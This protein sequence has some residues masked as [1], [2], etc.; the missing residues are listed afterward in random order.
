MKSI[1]TIAIAAFAL[2]FTFTAFSKSDWKEMNDFHSVM[3]KSFHPAEDGNFE[4]LKANAAD[5]LA[6]AKLWQASKIPADLNKEQTT[7]TLK[8]LVSQ[9]DE[10]NKAVIAKKSDAELLKLITK[11]HDIFHEIAEKCSHTEKEAEQK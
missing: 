2:V 9:C 7:K 5:L 8:Q 3:G 6:K 11:A 10:V 4:P 1:K